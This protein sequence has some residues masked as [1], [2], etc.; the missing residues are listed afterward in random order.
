MGHQLNL[1]LRSQ[2]PYDKSGY[3]VPKFILPHIPQG[4]R[5]LIFASLLSAAIS[6][7]DSALNSLLAATVPEFIAPRILF[8]IAIQG[9]YNRSGYE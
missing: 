6:S 5:A 4:L 7:L 2:V 9:Q 1:F 8:I 3:L